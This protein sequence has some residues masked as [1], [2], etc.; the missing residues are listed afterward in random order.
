MVESRSSNL[1]PFH[2]NILSYEASAILV[3]YLGYSYEIMALLNRLSH[4][5]AFYSRAHHEY[6]DH[7]WVIAHRVNLKAG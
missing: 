3:S 5:T 2:P 1:L 6:L 4:R 7:Y